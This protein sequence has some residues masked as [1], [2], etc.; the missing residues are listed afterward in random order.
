MASLSRLAGV[1][2]LAACIPQSLH[3]QEFI[4]SLFRRTTDVA[5][6]A[7]IATIS[8]ASAIE[9][10]ES[11]L[12]GL[13]AEMLIRIS[14]TAS[15]WD[16]EAGLGFSYLTGFRA[17][18]PR[19]DMRGSV[20]AVP[21]LSI[22]ITHEKRAVKPYIGL[23]SGFMNLWNVQTYDEEGTPFRTTGET[24]QAGVTAGIAFHGFWAELSY[25]RREFQSLAY[26]GP[27]PPPAW[28]PRSM[29]LSGM[30]VRLGYQVNI[31]P[32]KNGSP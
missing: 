13:G 15:A 2:A 23:H 21:E 30:N 20:R 1:L 18:D 6:Y 32:T 24:M 26:G 12:Q 14:D 17:K 31:V 8:H 11:A 19:V 28:F 29:D 3:A 27:T 9:A 4:N 22:Y 16:V 25:R 7:Q 5:V 10:R